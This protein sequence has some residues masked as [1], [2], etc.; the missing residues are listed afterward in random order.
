MGCIQLV[1]ENKV[2]KKAKLHDI[3]EAILF[4]L[5]FFC[6]A[7]AFGESDE[8]MPNWIITRLIFA[9][10]AVGCFVALNKCNKQW[11]NNK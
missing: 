3:I 6:L 10:I 11:S 4:C 9:S 2:M 8:A 7:L 5:G 1:N